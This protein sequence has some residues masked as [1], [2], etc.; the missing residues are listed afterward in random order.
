MP[1]LPEPYIY[2]YV[3]DRFYY[4]KPNQS[5]VFEDIARHLSNQTRFNGA[6]VR[7]YSIAQHCVFVADILDEWGCDALTQYYGLHHDD[8][9]AYFGDVPTPLQVWLKKLNGGVDIIEQGKKAID[10]I[11]MPQL[12]V[13]WPAQPGIWQVVK[14]ADLAAFVC[15]AEQLFLTYPD[16]L[17][18]FV[19]QRGI[20]RTID[21]A[22]DPVSSEQAYTDY[23]A[24]DDFLATQL[25]LN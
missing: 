14:E 18:D 10:D 23:M 2:T 11:I 15:E 16:W 19:L 25:N 5:V 13:P 7:P 3:G 17:D 4:G 8:H 9:E 20:K 1:A 24:T 21:M 22:I 12:G 6:T